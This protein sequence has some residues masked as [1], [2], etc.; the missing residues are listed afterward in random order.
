MFAQNSGFD[1]AAF[2][3]FRNEQFLAFDGSFEDSNPQMFVQDSFVQRM[4]I[5]DLNAVV[6][7]DNKVAVMYL[8]RTK[9]IHWGGCCCIV[10]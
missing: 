1:R 8:Q 7:G 6:S 5:D 4:L 2:D 3:G 9:F 10:G